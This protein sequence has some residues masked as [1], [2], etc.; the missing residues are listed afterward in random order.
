MC[1]ELPRGVSSIQNADACYAV[2]SCEKARKK[3]LPKCSQ[4]VCVLSFSFVRRKS[5]T[6]MPMPCLCPASVALLSPPPKFS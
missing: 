5:P 4:A 1:V 2:A 3:K 6:P